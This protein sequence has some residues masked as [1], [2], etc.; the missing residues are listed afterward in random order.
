[1]HRPESALGRDQDEEEKSERESERVSLLAAL[2]QLT[3]LE[4]SFCA[5]A[6]QFGFLLTV[7]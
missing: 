2:L 5:F 3:L 7:T 1:M 4:S 6:V